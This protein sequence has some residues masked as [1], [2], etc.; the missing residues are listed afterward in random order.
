MFASVL[1]ANRGEIACRIARTAKK[2]GLRTIA[3]YSDADAG[4]LHTRLCDEA[5]RLGPAPARE[6]YLAIDKL[7]ELARRTGAQCVH[8]G[9]GFLS[10]NAEFAEACA[11][12]GIVFVGPPPAA[13]RAMGLK[14][15]AKKLME[16][17]GVPVVP[18]YHGERQE[19]KFLAQKA[20]EVGYPVLIKAVAGG[21]GRGMRRVDQAAELE[22]ALQSAIREAQSAFGNGQVL[23]EKYIASP[24]H[25]EIQVFGDRHGNAM[26]LFE[27]DCSLQRRHQKV[28]EEAPAPGMTPEVRAAM[29]KAAVE[30]A[31]AVGYVGAGTVEFIADGSK[32]LRRNAFWFM[33][34]NTRL[35]VEHPV[36]EAVTGLDLVEWQF[37]VAAGEKLPSLDVALA[38]H[39]V[40][41]RVYAEDPERGFLPSTGRIIAL[42]FPAHDGIRVDAGVEQ[43]MEVTPFYDPL[44][45]K[46]IAHGATRRAA[47]EALASALDRTLVAGPNTNLAFLAAL[48]RAEDFRKAQFDTGFIDR[49]LAALG[50]VPKEADRAA[51]AKGVAQ[52]LAREAKRIAARVQSASEEAT[53]PWNSLDGFQLCGARAVSIPV[54]IHGA[55]ASASA[56]YGPQGISVAID[57]IP[58]APDARAF[59]AENAVYVL[60]HGRQTVVRIKDFEAI[61][62]EHLDTGGLIVAPMHGKVLA[63]LVRPGASVSR[64]QRLA[65]IEAM[66]MEHALIAPFD[67]T[68]GEILATPG[69][70]LAEGAKVMTIE[71]KKTEPV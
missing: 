57:G 14:G 50:A 54:S 7:V 39:A 2:L 48:C 22:A 60:H 41:A 21:G 49:N 70:Q 13:I 18:G 42:E 20:E 9:Y 45:A 27:R 8:P 11:V 31:K 6:S 36:T 28:I 58:A 67:G 65:V 5:H 1:I 3:V 68:V 35:Q 38:G 29:G 69:G 61:D 19:T 32:G 46:V 55:P 4:A 23:I 51:A 25:V 66:K 56:S 71:A 64:G 30:A 15:E 52:L 43:G 63:I 16:H 12:A 24:R 26:H 53:S 37:R 47:L 59:E 40:E 44:I 33:E 34:M 17:A 10:E 62:V